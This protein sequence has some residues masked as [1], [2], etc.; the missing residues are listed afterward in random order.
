MSIRKPMSHILS[1]A[2]G[3]VVAT[4]ALMALVQPASAQRG[5]NQVKID[6]GGESEYSKSI[7]LPLNKAAI[8]NLPSSAADVL[9]SQ[10]SIVD[11]VVRSSRRVYLLGLSV[12]E[13]NAFFFDNQGRQ[14]L[15]LEIRVERDM[16]AIT[17]LLRRLMPDS[18]I[19][20]DAI[21]DNVVIRGS[22]NSNSEA[23]NAQT[24]VSR[25]VGNPDNVINMLSVRQRD[26]V[27]LRVRV[28]EMQH[29]LM[30][31]LGV[32]TNG[33]VTLDD[34][35]L[36]FA[37]SNAVGATGGFS[38]TGGI[39]GPIG[40]LTNLDV[41]FEALETTGLVRILAEPNLTAISGES[42]NFLAGGEFPVPV[43]QRNGIL[44]VE[45]REFGV[46]LGFTPV[47]LDKGRINL[48][49]S[50]EVSD[51]T[52]DNAI[53]VPGAT[54]VDADG[55]LI[56][57]PSLQIPGLSVRRANTTVE[58]ASGGSLVMAGLLQEDLRSTMQ[59]VPG[60]KDVAVLGQ[61]FRS[62]DFENSQ[63]E[64]V[65]IVTPFIVKGT[66]LANLTDPSEGFVPASDLQN[67][68]FGKVAST[69]GLANTDAGDKSLQGPLGFIL[70]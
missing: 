22:V 58:L 67:I 56:A 41:A 2:K 20:L 39:N 10:P 42:A 52:T 70:D 24:V 23:A 32:N 44:S 37:A 63:T 66:Q 65:I 34:I 26:Q 62:R 49:V 57:G 12:G 40:D 11:A 55:Q 14:I 9:V 60:L 15:N 47:V 36:G 61:L 59:G 43:G 38:G 18:R 17:D 30:K 50:T 53:I 48:K 46:G 7:I 25:F 6:M 8:V 16:D 64:L 45:F 68:L 21:N 3:L 35:Q 4:A 1:A 33:T 51:I 13:T 29:Q 31:Q 5:I 27:M 54:T 69:Y 19:T 28:V